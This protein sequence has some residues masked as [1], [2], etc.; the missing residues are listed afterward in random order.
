EYANVNFYTVYKPGTPGVDL[1][2]RYWL[3]GVEFV[4]GQPYVFALIHFA[5]EP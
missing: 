2:F 5:W 3:V 4:Q 1:D